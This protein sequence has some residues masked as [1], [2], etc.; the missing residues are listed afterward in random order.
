ME[1]DKNKKLEEP[2]EEE[3]EELLDVIKQLEETN[4][5]NKKPPKRNMIAIE[6]G[7]VFHPNVYIN[8]AFTY[9][10]NLALTYLLIELLDLA[11][12]E[13]F[14]ILALFVLGYTLIEYFYRLY[15]MYKHFPL[16][17]RSFG[18]IFYFG[19][20][21]IVYV[22]DLYVFKQSFNFKEGILL[23]VYITFFTIIRYFLSIY[24]RRRVR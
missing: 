2:T 17:I 20:I 13:S 12:F 18:T 15:V 21:V 4:K 6:F 23:M 24:I 9:L 5:N 14:T 10:L 19:Y 22:L 11:E 16:I 8:V 7:G 3:L 1:E